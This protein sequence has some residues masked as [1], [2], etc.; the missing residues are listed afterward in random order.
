MAHAEALAIDAEQM[1]VPVLFGGHFIPVLS[2]MV[3]DP[4]NFRKLDVLFLLG[5]LRNLGAYMPEVGHPDSLTEG[6]NSM[7]RMAV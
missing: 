1:L 2:E 7:T 3:H 6:R 4:L 5:D